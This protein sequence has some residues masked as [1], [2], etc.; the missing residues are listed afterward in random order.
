MS[1]YSLIFRKLF[2]VE[3]FTARI[4]IDEAVTTILVDVPAGTRESG[5]MATL[6]EDVAVV[7]VV[8]GATVTGGV[9]RVG[10]FLVTLG[11]SSNC[12]TSIDVRGNTGIG[13]AMVCATLGLKAIIFMP[14]NCSKERIAMMKAFGAEVRLTP[15]KDGMAGAVR[16]AKK[17]AETNPSSFIPDQFENKDN[18]LAHYKTTGPEIYRQMDGKI[19]IL[20]AAFGTGGTLTGIARYLKERK[21]GIR[22]IG[23]EPK[24][25][26]F[27]TEGHGGSHK[28][29]GIGAGFK[30]GVLELSFV[31]EVRTITNEEAYEF[32]RL[33]CRKEGLFCGISSGCNLAGAVKEAMKKENEGKN[34]VTVLPDNGERYLSVEGLYD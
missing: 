31:D 24:T 18:S 11:G 23:L 7:A 14:E 29:Q 28:I 25:S 33:L 19:D 22:C 1:K 17:L 2:T 6:E 10:S 12:T 13:L 9:N 15:A 27:V 16:E 30:P 21:P 20:V 5:H 34:I 4:G 26:P 32:T 3:V 8:G